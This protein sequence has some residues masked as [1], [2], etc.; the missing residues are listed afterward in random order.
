MYAQV[1]IENQTLVQKG[2]KE[3]FEQFD[4]LT[5]K[6]KCRFSS[7]KNWTKKNETQTSK[8]RIVTHCYTK[9]KKLAQKK[10][11]QLV[12]DNLFLHSIS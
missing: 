5:N 8:S 11:Q 4:L 7:F 12:V 1:G 9:H 6:Q 3:D 2:K 10:I